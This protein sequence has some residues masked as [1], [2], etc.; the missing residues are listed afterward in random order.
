[1]SSMASIEGSRRP[2]IL[3]PNTILGG[4]SV[5]RSASVSSEVSGTG[6][7]ASAASMLT[8]SFTRTINVQEYLKSLG[9]TTRR[10]MMLQRLDEQDIA[11]TEAMQLKPQF[12]LDSYLDG[13]QDDV[14]T[15]DDDHILAL[16]DDQT[17]DFSSITFAY[18]NDYVYIPLV[19][20]LSSP[21]NFAQRKFNEV[22]RHILT[23]ERLARVKLF[24]NRWSNVLSGRPTDITSANIFEYGAQRGLW[25]VNLKLRAKA[26]SVKFLEKKIL[27]E[28]RRARELFV[29][30][31][32]LTIAAFD[33]TVNS[34][35]LFLLVCQ[36]DWNKMKW[37][38]AIWVE[39]TLCVIIATLLRYYEVWQVRSMVLCSI[40]G[41]FGV[42]TILVRPYTEDL[43]FWLDMFGR[44]LVIFC[45]LSTI[46]VFDRVPDSNFGPISNPIRDLNSEFSSLRHP[47]SGASNSNSTSSGDIFLYFLLD[48]CM[49]LFFYAYLVYMLN[50]LGVYTV[51]RNALTDFQYR[52]YDHTLNFLI[53]KSHEQ[54]LGFEDVFTGL[55][56]I[57]Q[58]D[59]VIVSQRRYLFLSYP[60]IRPASILPWY[61]KLV[62]VQLAAMCNL[63]ISRLSSSLGLTLLHASMC[64]GNTEVSKW[65]MHA[66]PALLSLEDSQRDTP[67]MIALKECAYYLILYGQQNNGLMDDGTSYGDA[68]FDSY[69]PEI[70]NYRKQTSISGEF[71]VE[72]AESYDLTSFDLN[73]LAS[74]GFLPLVTFPRENDRN[75]SH[76]SN[77]DRIKSNTGEI[78]MKAINSFESPF[79]SRPAS[80]V[81]SEI[82]SA[83]NMIMSKS[84]AHA[85]LLVRRRLAQEKHMKYLQEKNS[86][87]SKRFDEDDVVDDYESGQMTSWKTVLGFPVPE[88]NLYLDGN[89]LELQRRELEQHRQ[90]QQI[91]RYHDDAMDL[92]P[93][94]L[95]DMNYEDSGSEFGQDMNWMQ[96]LTINDQDDS[97]LTDNLDRPPLRNFPL[98]GP[99]ALTAQYSRQQLI[100]MASNAHFKTPQSPIRKRY[101]L[102]TGVDS[103]GSTKSARMSSH[104]LKK[105]LAMSID[106]AVTA[107]AVDSDFPLDLE[108]SIYPA[109]KPV[110]DIG[111]FA[112]PLDVMVT[113][114]ELQDWQYQVDDLIRMKR[115]YRRIVSTPLY[116]INNKLFFAG[117]SKSYDPN[118]EGQQLSH[119]EVE[120]ETEDSKLL[121]DHRSHNSHR[122]GSVV[123]QYEIIYQLSKFTEIF[124]SDELFRNSTKISWDV[125]TY[126]E[127]GSIASEQQARLAQHLA[128]VLQLNP[129]RGFALI[130][131]WMIGI[132]ARKNYSIYIFL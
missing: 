102:L 20:F 49:S 53:E 128:M 23:S 37:S 58:W 38:L 30:D 122:K 90:M 70:E 14:D 50:V 68:A 95:Q 31:D 78:A 21:F 132:N 34:A 66:Y 57:Q 103:R 104:S 118:F 3:N 125:S 93:L 45:T 48:V 17:G 9:Q 74:H 113:R 110:L 26:L 123:L 112:V 4:M 65:L 127:M 61:S 89:L 62:E 97:A 56:L 120:N 32:Q 117:N 108:Y 54:T 72:L 105:R 59:D 121:R 51:I 98:A 114:K 76:S 63:T 1:M 40:T 39:M 33:C 124:L 41:F 35:G 5:S 7:N 129:P 77:N 94:L 126:K 64:S 2:S 87:L 86:L 11:A 10:D 60:D 19:A 131:E 130:S 73:H 43:D 81:Q 88:T 79:N 6:S 12:D 111:A 119:E 28:L 80:R 47:A 109:N 8:S 99:N 106:S 84:K 100:Q 91:I 69:Y 16:A 55:K 83:T 107:N 44:S 96:S 13:E 22:K 25:R 115:S 71:V 67:L 46:F 42:L 29:L 18:V 101:P 85:S 27:D 116:G 92:D 36:Y 24:Y 82:D 75:I 15:M 52:L